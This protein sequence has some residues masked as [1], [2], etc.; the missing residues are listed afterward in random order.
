LSP[1]T[2][3]AGS[4]PRRLL[5]EWGPVVAWAGLIF[6]F[7]AQANL[8]F[9]SEESLDFAIRKAGHM[10]VFGT[11]AVLLWRALASEA[12]KWARPLAWV[13]TLLYAAS[14]EFHQGFTAGR[15]PSPI[16]VTI[17]ATGALIGLTVASIALRAFRDREP[18][19][20]LIRRS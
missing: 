4:R 9:A 15:H 11:L 7:S 16:D 18:I 19:A 1:D 2:P 8:R 14:D 17:D 6:W 5:L 13:G 10:F 12:V 20:S 3:V